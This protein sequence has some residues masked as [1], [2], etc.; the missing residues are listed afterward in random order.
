M[1]RQGPRKPGINGITNM[2]DIWC[3][4]RFGLGWEVVRV[5]HKRVIGQ[6]GAGEWLVY[7]YTRLVGKEKPLQI[8]PQD[9]IMLIDASNINPSSSEID[10]DN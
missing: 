6:L 10:V 7:F 2:P 1:W 9:A 8:V 5:N 3:R 4:F